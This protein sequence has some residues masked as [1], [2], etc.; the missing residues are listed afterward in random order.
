[1]KYYLLNATLLINIM[2]SS[3]AFSKDLETALQAYEAKK[4][5]GSAKTP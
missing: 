3:P 4:L 5:F 2:L 1:M